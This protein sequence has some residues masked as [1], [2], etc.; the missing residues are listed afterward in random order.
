MSGTI[1]NVG[2]SI[3]ICRPNLADYGDFSYGTLYSVAATWTDPAGSEF[4]TVVDD[5]GVTRNAQ[6]YL[7]MSLTRSPTPGRATTQRGR[8]FRREIAECDASE[9]EEIMAAQEAYERA[10]S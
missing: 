1:F 9:Y 10:A 6:A 7:F 2:D 4:V 3:C 5:G 8:E